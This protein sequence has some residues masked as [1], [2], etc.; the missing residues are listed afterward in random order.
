M[1]YPR[2]HLVWSALVTNKRLRSY[3]SKDGEDR[4]KFFYTS[5]IL[6]SRIPFASTHFFVALSEDHSSKVGEVQELVENLY[7]NSIFNN[8]RLQT[9]HEWKEMLK[10]LDVPSSD[11]VLLLTYDDHAFIDDSAQEL[12]EIANTISD[13]QIRNPLYGLITHFPEVVSSIET[14]TRFGLA[15]KLNDCFLV[16]CRKPLGALLLRKGDLEDMFSED[17]WGENLIVA[18]EN[19]FGPS[20]I[21]P[22]ALGLIPKRELFRHLDGYRHIGISDSPFRPYS[23]LDSQ[24]LKSIAIIDSVEYQGASLPHEIVLETLNIEKN[25]VNEFARVN[26]RRISFQVSKYCAVVSTRIQ[27]C[28]LLIYSASRNR[29]VLR[30]LLWAPLYLMLDIAIS[31]VRNLFREKD[32]MIISQVRTFAELYTAF[33]PSRVLLILAKAKIKCS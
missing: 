19:Y 6:N 12:L 18:P 31:L 30:N 1:S 29:L 2:I 24:R 21:T 13:S 26:S 15:S 17:I 20:V 27:F 10:S 32:F 23:P 11:L 25:R 22:T 4:L 7:V 33:R 28:A 14:Y 3:G 16:P 8:F 9:Y 5:L